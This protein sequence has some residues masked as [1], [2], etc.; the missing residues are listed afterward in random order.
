VYI[1]TLDSPDMHIIVFYAVYYNV[2]VNIGSRDRSNGTQSDRACTD[3]SGF[4]HA[5]DSRQT[6]HSSTGADFYAVPH[7][8]VEFFI[9]SELY[10]IKWMMLHG[11]Q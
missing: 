4:G 2:D 7:S 3:Y 1:H 8:A 5:T 6:S 11:L 10:N 9:E